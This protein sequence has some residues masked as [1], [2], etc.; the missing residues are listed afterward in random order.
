MLGGWEKAGV[1][2]RL[3]SRGGP[4]HSCWELLTPRGDGLFPDMTTLSTQSEGNGSGSNPKCCEL[5]GKP[6]N[7]SDPSLLMLED[8]K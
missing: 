6:L 3:G 5:L 7:I 2:H 8:A 1:Q 4:L